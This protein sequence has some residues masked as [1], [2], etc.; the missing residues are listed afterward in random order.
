[1]AASS[2][3]AARTS[4]DVET[5]F[6]QYFSHPSI[7]FLAPANA[8]RLFAARIQDVLERQIAYLPGESFGACVRGVPSAP[9]VVGRSCC[10]PH[11]RCCG[12]VCGCVFSVLS[13]NSLQQCMPIGWLEAVTGD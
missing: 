1:M 8:D 11:L 10:W 2:S 7:S 5:S 13:C 9:P 12:R 3:A 6:L 4:R